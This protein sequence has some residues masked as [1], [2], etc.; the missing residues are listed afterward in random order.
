MDVIPN[1]TI[2]LRMHGRKIFNS[3]SVFLALTGNIV[4]QV[5]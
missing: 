1:Y 5:A 3:Y 4:L 2:Y